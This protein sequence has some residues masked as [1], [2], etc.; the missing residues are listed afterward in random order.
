[1]LTAFSSG[2]WCPYHISPFDEESF[3]KKAI[4]SA[5]VLALTRGTPSFPKPCNDIIRRKRTNEKISHSLSLRFVI[6]FLRLDRGFVGIV[7]TS[8]FSWHC[9][10]F[11]DN[12]YHRLLH[13]FFLF[14][15]GKCSLLDQIGTAQAFAQAFRGVIQ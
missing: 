14:K 11:A 9:E 8:F 5:K 4:L 13:H 12:F 3:F 1:M 2:Q 15:P 6:D 10:T 7:L